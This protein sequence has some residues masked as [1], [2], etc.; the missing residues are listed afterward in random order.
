MSTRHVKSPRCLFLFFSSCRDGPSPLS[1]VRPRRRLSPAPTACC[2]SRRAQMLSRL[3]ALQRPHP[4][5]ASAFTAIEHDGRL[6]GSG[7]LTLL[8]VIYPSSCR[9]RVIPITDISL[10]GSCYEVPW[11]VR[12]SHQLISGSSDPACQGAACMDDRAGGMG[13]I[14]RTADWHFANLRCAP[15]ATHPTRPTHPTGVSE[16]STLSTLSRKGRS[17]RN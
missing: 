15:T 8:S 17:L 11:R 3:A 4:P 16:L 9:G 13:L 5:G 14:F 2:R 10:G 7:R 12:L 6:D 1:L